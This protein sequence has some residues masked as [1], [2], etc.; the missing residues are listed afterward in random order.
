MMNRMHWLLR[1][2]AVGHFVWGLIFVLFAAYVTYSAFA[3]LAYMSSGNIWSKLAAAMFVTI[4]HS[5]PFVLLG[6]WILILGRRT[7]NG[8]QPVRKVLLV[9]HGILFVIGSLSVVMGIYAIR[10]AEASIA[11]GGGLLSPIA[12]VPLILGFLLVALALPS[13]IIALTAAP[14]TAD[15]IKTKGR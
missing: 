14:K 12:W 13:I 1:G 3:V 10:D 5:L 7:W 6:G 15:T 9:T 4:Q 2:M 11:R 8:A